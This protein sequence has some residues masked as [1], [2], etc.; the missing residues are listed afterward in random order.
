MYTDALS[1]IGR[2][3]VAVDGKWYRA[4]YS[5]GVV[6]AVGLRRITPRVV[7]IVPGLGRTLS[8]PSKLISGIS[9]IKQLNLCPPR[10]N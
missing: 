8:L 4:Q 5:R 7:V 9:L 2:H 6:C 10:T 1:S 3:L